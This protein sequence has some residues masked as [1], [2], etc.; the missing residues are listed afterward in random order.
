[1]RVLGV[2]SGSSLDGLDLACCSFE[3]TADRW[4][5]TMEAATTVPYD[6]TWRER[7][8]A[9]MGRSALELALIDRDLGRLI[10]ERCARFI[11]EH[12][13]KPDLIASHGHTV[14]HAPEKGL[15]LQIGSGA[16]IAAIA[17]LP[18]AFD[19]RAKDVALGGQGA[20]LVPLGE[21]ELFPTTMP[22][23]ISAALRTCPFKAGRSSASMCA[24]ATRR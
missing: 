19:F 11:K 1:M 15:T 23:S 6:D 17:G 18:V 16:S 3:R 13:V 20:P 14:F 9:V 21:R 24:F 10:G 12:G 22:S 7:L 5:Y 8:P 4:R 2:M